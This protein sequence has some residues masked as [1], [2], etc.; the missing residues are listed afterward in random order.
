MT[1]QLRRLDSQHSV[2]LLLPCVFYIRKYSTQRDPHKCAANHR[3][4]AP[5]LL[6]K[7]KAGKEIDVYS[8]AILMCEGKAI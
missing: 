7:Q 6:M 8:F 5:E 4:M 2:F 3:Y 1:I